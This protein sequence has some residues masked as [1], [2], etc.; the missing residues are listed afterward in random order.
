MFKIENDFI[1][2]LYENF[3][4]LGLNQVVGSGNLVRTIIVIKHRLICLPNISMHLAMN[5]FVEL[6]STG[7]VTFLKLSFLLLIALPLVLVTST[8]LY[9]KKKCLS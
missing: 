7:S 3:A 2:N 9:V 4:G 8:I 5:S 1:F 6:V